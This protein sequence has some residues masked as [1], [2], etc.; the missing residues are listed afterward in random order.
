MLP[1]WFFMHQRPPANELRRYEDEGPQHRVT[2][3][4]PFGIGRYTVT[5]DEYEQF[6]THTKRKFPSDQDWGRGSQ[7]II[8]VSWAEALEYC[9]WLTQQSGVMYRLPSEAEWEYAARAGTTT[10]YWWGNDLDT[11]QANYNGS[12]GRTMLVRCF[13]PNP[14]G[15]Y[16]VHGNVWEFCQDHWHHNYQG[17]PHNEQ[18]WEDSNPNRRVARGGAWHPSGISCRS[19]TRYSIIDE[20]NYSSCGFRVCCDLID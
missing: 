14:F 6:C 15:L 8:N 9:V 7:P 18:A 5:F 2:I 1:L 11:H 20:H 12:R 16:Q 4:K 10:A 19:A 13:T 3:S 17:A